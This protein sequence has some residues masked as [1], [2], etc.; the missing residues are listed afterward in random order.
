MCWRT[1][2]VEEVLRF[3]LVGGFATAVLVFGFNALVPGAL[4]GEALDQAREMAQQHSE[5]LKHSAQQ[6]AARLQADFPEESEMW[7]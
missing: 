5:H 1:P 7:G 3:L 4:I 6:I 2:I